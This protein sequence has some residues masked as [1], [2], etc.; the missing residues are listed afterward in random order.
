MRRIWTEAPAMILFA[1]L[2][3]ARLLAQ[4]SQPGSRADGAGGPPEEPKGISVASLLQE[5][6]DPWALALA[7]DPAFESLVF[8]SRGSPG[9]AVADRPEGFLKAEKKGDRT[10]Y[11]MAECDGPG[12]LVRVTLAR[13]C[14]T[15]RV[16]ADESPL[17]ILDVPAG[18]WVAGGITLFGG[19]FAGRFG[20]GGAVRFP[21]PFAAH[22]K[23]T[24]DQPGFD[25][26]LAVRRYAKSEAIETFQVKEA[27]ISTFRSRPA[28]MR[29]AEP[30]T[31][32]PLEVSNNRTITVVGTPTAVV[33]C[34]ARETVTIFE[35]TTDRPAAITHL[36]FIDGAQGERIDGAASPWESL[37]VQIIFDGVRTVDCPLAILVGA[38]DPGAER[39]G[40]LLGAEKAGFL[41][42]RNSFV[43]PFQKSVSVLVRNNADLPVLGLLAQ[44]KVEENPR[45]KNALRFHA[46]VSDGGA[47]EYAVPAGARLVARAY[48]M[49]REK[50]R[51]ESASILNALTP[52]EL[53]RNAFALSAIDPKQPFTSRFETA[54]AA[55]L[56]GRFLRTF[57]IDAPYTKNGARLADLARFY[58]AP[59]AAGSKKN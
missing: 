13:A 21:I 35:R 57:T 14:G 8:S 52:T 27:I 1:V 55:N 42:H 33:H 29:L 25:Y 10:E 22:I 18:L 58:Y 30:A 45:A 51:L 19:P 41:Q 37:A 3:A 20:D 26:E 44:I 32:M 28:I 12:V 56:N 31:K 50:D 40:F 47:A 23:V 24:C 11:V 5:M 9:T 54:S 53:G 59:P 7:P 43:M 15:L 16:Y 39:P 49:R 38:F 6:A 36:G 46:S 4:D 34:G 17:P 2:T 48:D